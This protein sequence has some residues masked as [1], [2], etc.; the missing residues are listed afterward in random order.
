MEHED[1]KENT[2]LV[3]GGVQISLQ[4]CLILYSIKQ[5]CRKNQSDKGVNINLTAIIVIKIKKVSVSH[6]PH[7]ILFEFVFRQNYICGPLSQT[8]FLDWSIKVLFSR[9]ALVCYIILSPLAFL[10]SLVKINHV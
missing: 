8:F 6:T 3:S 1:T 2:T 5:I 7:V 9:I 4:F 10:T